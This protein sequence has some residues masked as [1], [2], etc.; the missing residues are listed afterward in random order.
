MKISSEAKRTA[1][2]LFDISLVNGRIDQ[3]KSVMIADTI[4]ST[5]PRHAFQLLK[6]FTRLTRLELSHHQA[7][8]ESATPLEPSSQAAMIAA[9]QSRDDQVD[10]S[11]IV[12]PSLLGGARVR[13]GSDV[14]DG[15]VR[16]KIEK[17][18][19]L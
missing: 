18:K 13:L 6:E 9:L 17:L 3:A 2:Q 19:N 15:T 8:V 11:M 12:N 10:I 14:W 5:R 7:V 16:A 4:I 1:R